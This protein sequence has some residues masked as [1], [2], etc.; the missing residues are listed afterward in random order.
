MAALGTTRVAGLTN[1][2]SLNIKKGNSS[3]DWRKYVSRQPTGPTDINGS[4]II[5]APSYDQ[6]G[7]DITP[8][9][10]GGTK[11]AWSMDG[12]MDGLA[13]LV[14]TDAKSLAQI[15]SGVGSTVD[16]VGGVYDIYAKNRAAKAAEEDAAYK[17]SVS[18]EKLALAR[19]D[20]AEF[21]GYRG[22]NTTKFNNAAAMT[23]TM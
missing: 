3:L 19:Q 23:R 9:N 4:T 21:R 6:N 22:T 1:L 12:A 7:F 10:T 13:G 5:G 11:P 18:E 15:G 20:R 8:V 2:P 16:I 14:G 17:R